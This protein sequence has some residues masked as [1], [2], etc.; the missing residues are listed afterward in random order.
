[1]RRFLA[2]LLFVAPLFAQNQNV[3]TQI[4]GSSDNA[5]SALVDT[6]G[7]F[8]VVV[9]NGLSCTPADSKITCTGTF[10]TSAS[11]QIVAKAVPKTASLGLIAL[12]KLAEYQ[13]KPHYRLLQNS[14]VTMAGQP[15]IFQILTYEE[16]GNVQLG[17]QIQI[18][19]ILRSG[20]LVESVF[21]C[22][23]FSC[24]AY[25][26]SMQQIYNSL[27]LAPLDANGKPVA[28]SLVSKTQGTTLVP[29]ADNQQQIQEFIQKFGL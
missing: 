15:A 22:G 3:L 4:L 16:L 21:Q 18:V 23:S 12:N 2:C 26:T 20:V 5:S 25:A 13:S 14:H 17:T 19:D 9:P 8:S 11:L 10:G 27:A 7:Y 24:S 6:A 29:A 1:M 28:G